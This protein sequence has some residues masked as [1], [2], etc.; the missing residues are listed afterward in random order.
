MA[1]IL[2]TSALPY[3]NGVK[4]LGNLAGSMLPADVYARFQRARGHEVLYVCATDE[5]GTPAELAAAAAG[6]DVRTYC[7]EQHAIQRDIGAAFGLSWDWFGRSSSPANHRLT[8]HFAEVLEKN[9]LIEERT[10]RMI[11]SVADARF[12]PDRYVEGTCPHCNYEKAR[13]DQ[14]D[15][16][17]RLLDPTDLKDPYSVISGSRDLE[18]RETRHLYLLQTRMEAEIR[19]WVGTKDWPALARSIA[20]KHLDEGLIDRGIT[21]DLSWGV[22]VTKDGK[23]RP[24]FETKVFYVW[25][26]APIEYI[27]ATVEWA[28]ATGA[29]WKRWWRLDAGAEDVRYVQ[30]MGKDNVA[31]HTVS[32]PATILGSK[33][34]WK[35]VDTLKA[36]NWLNWYG[37]KFSTSQSRGVFMDQALEILPADVWR[38][39]L[40]SNAPEGSDTAFTWEQFQATV[41][42]DLADVLGNFVN[43]IVKFAE[44][45]FE[46]QV[47]AG[48]EPGP[49]ETQLYADVGAA[50]AELTAQFEVLEFR[51]A[52]QALRRLWVIGNE[53]LTEAAPWTALKTD[54]D[55]AAVIVRTGLN[56]VALFAAVS[57]PIL[58]FT[59]TKIAAAVGEPD[60]ARWPEADGEAELTRLPAGR[61]VAAG[62]VLFRKIEDADVAAWA[63][64]FGGA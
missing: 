44:S 40:V 43:R 6:Q 54:R 16:C 14:C 1:R 31:F 29:D 22:P 24:G 57:R 2:I 56:L 37:G 46:G 12:L 34:P 53:Y 45:R 9:G 59:A 8:Q 58:P 64:R 18:V 39:Y 5:H 49:L 41:N 20:Y 7:D 47:P 55:R 10:D 42:K 21:R 4:H 38:W 50:L 25:F 63:E 11:Y 35:T 33:E 30:V 23:P 13:G 32:F 26:D 36:F 60:E 27:G 15:S 17:G 62:E 51:K 52:A 3:I 48:G 19:A 28:E 61:P